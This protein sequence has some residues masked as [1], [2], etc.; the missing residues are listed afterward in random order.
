MDDSSLVFELSMLP[1]CTLQKF[2][3]W[4]ISYVDRHIGSAS[5]A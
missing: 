5:I 2:M 4:T 1:A 3:K